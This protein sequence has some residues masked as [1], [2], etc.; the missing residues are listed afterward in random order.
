MST[1]KQPLSDLTPNQAATELQVDIKTI[2]RRIADGSLPAY[3]IAA[4]SDP[5]KGRLIRIRRKDLEALKV[6][7]MTGGA[8]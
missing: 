4:A 8:A 6:P 5:E 7:L 2:Y 3:R 1:R